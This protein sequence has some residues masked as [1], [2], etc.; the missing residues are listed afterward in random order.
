MIDD[1][2]VHANKENIH[3]ALLDVEK[4]KQY[5]LVINATS[6]GIMGNDLPM[7][8]HLFSSSTTYYDMTYGSELLVAHSKKCF[9]EIR[10]LTE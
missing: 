10:L 7:P 4:I 1:W 3:L 2:S 5:D 6:A 8:I 9:A